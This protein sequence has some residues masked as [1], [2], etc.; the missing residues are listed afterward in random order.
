V[1]KEHRKQ[2]SANVLNT[3]KEETN[4]RNEEKSSRRNVNCG[5]RN[6]QKNERKDC[7]SNNRENVHCNKRGVCN[8]R[9]NAFSSK[10]ENK[11]YNDRGLNDRESCKKG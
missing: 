10:D 9:K 6:R 2:L 8:N 5:L 11:S 7:L 4:Y 3:K 1:R